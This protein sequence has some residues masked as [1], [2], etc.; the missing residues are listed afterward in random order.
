MKANREA[1]HLSFPLKSQ[2]GTSGVSNS[3][4][5]TKFVPSTELEKQVRVHMDCN[6]RSQEQLLVE[7]G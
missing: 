1:E 5:A 4:L 3:E 7:C 6:L 2:L